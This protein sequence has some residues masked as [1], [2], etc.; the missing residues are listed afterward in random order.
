M[1]MAAG[2]SS[3]APMPKY[4]IRAAAGGG[5]PV[6]GGTTLNGLSR[7]MP[8]AIHAGRQRVVAMPFPQHQRNSRHKSRRGPKPTSSGAASPPLS[9]HHQG[10]TR[11]GVGIGVGRRGHQQAARSR[12][13]GETGGAVR[14][15]QH[16]GSKANSRKGTV[17]RRQGRQPAV[18][19][20]RKSLPRPEMGRY[21]GRSARFPCSAAYPSGPPTPPSPS[22]PTSGAPVYG[23]GP[24]V[25]AVHPCYDYEARFTRTGAEAWGSGSRLGRSPFGAARAPNP[26]CPALHTGSW[27][28]EAG[29]GLPPPYCGLGCGGGAPAIPQP[30]FF[31]WVPV[32]C[33]PAWVWVPCR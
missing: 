7:Y 25:G 32:P 23:V 27:T 2:G 31:V 22:Q 11:Q 13:T 16:S 14:R 19:W 10:F 1:G 18:P 17:H 6:A 5:S 8:R 3:T 30:Y 33:P 21:Q 20:Q 9:H 24:G 28:A 15:P 29:C 26:W 4:P 12:V